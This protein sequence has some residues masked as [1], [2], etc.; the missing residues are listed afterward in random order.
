MCVVDVFIV[1][2]YDISEMSIN[3]RLEALCTEGGAGAGKRK[4]A[5]LTLCPS[6]TSYTSHLLAE[7]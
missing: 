2:T 1:P 6:Y 3:N 5:V 7:N 4:R